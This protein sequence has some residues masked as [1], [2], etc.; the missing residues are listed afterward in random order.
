[1]FR[2]RRK[3]EDARRSSEFSAS[4]VIFY[5]RTARSELESL[6]SGVSSGLRGLD[7]LVA[8]KFADERDEAI[9]C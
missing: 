4:R 7:S 1:M 2:E 8:G 5:F 3:K 9:I 6:P